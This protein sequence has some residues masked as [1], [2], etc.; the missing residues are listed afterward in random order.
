MLDQLITLDKLN[1]NYYLNQQL[2]IIYEIIL[3]LENINIIN[4]YK[5]DN[6]LIIN[7]KLNN[8]ICNN[9]NSNNYILCLDILD[10]NKQ[11]IYNLIQYKAKYT[12]FSNNTRYK[13][14]A[15]IYFN[16]TMEELYKEYDSNLTTNQILKA[17]ISLFNRNNIDNIK[18]YKDKE[19][20]YIETLFIN[21]FNNS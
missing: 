18:L 4:F 11:L 14:V 2:N 13:L 21:Y 12:N 7:K 1:V 17:K 8:N 15:L 3:K 6:V 9:S 19:S 20:K 16:N 5:D 10:N